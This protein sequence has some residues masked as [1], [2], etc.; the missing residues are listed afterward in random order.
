MIFTPLSELI[1]NSVSEPL[2]W[3]Q[4][5]KQVISLALQNTLAVGLPNNTPFTL[6]IHK[7]E[8]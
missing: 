3:E 5:H 2:P 7:H 1:R 4:N 8:N 6:F